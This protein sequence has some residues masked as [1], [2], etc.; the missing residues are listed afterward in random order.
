MFESIKRW[1]TRW[2]EPLLWLPLVGL[3][4]LGAWVLLGALDETAVADSLSLLMNLPI[5]SAY[6]FAASGLAYLIWR[7]WSYRLTVEQLQALWAGLMRGERGPL[8]IFVVN[9][10]FYICVTLGLLL[11]FFS[12]AQR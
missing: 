3:L 11:F 12:L 8:V 5:V 6:A 4:I 10:G 9:A 1:L 2:Q 7:R